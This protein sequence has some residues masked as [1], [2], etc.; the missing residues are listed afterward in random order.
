MRLLKAAPR[1]V[2]GGGGVGIG[3]GRDRPCDDSIQSRLFHN[4]GLS[5]PRFPRFSRRLFSSHRFSSDGLH[6]LPGQQGA[7]DA[8]A[9]LSYFDQGGQRREFGWQ[10]LGFALLDGTAEDLAQGGCIIQGQSP[11]RFGLF[12]IAAQQG[13]QSADV[14]ETVSLVDSRLEMNRKSA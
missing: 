1:K 9:M 11:H 3:V 2:V 4:R 12:H 13:M 6:G 7:A 14:E 5:I 8:R 10:G